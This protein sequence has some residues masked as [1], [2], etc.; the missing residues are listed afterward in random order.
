MTPEQVLKHY[1]TAWKFHKETGM[2]NRSLHNWLEWGRI[3]IASQIKIHKFTNG[4]LKAELD[5]LVNEC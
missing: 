5:D 3:P 2:S 1:K 4:V